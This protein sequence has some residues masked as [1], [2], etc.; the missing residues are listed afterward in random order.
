MHLKS[1]EVQTKRLKIAGLRNSVTEGVPLIALHGWLD[2]AASFDF[3][4]D[5]LSV[6][7]PFFAIDLPGHGQSEHRPA[8]SA[9]HLLENILD[10]LAF[11][12][13]MPDLLAANNHLSVNSPKGKVTELEL[14]QSV[15]PKVN[16]LGHSLGGIIACLVAAAAP[17]RVEKLILLDSLGPLTDEIEAVLPQ[18]RKAVAKASKLKSSLSVFPNLEMAIRARMAGLGRINREA[19]ERLVC[20]GVQAVEGGVIWSSDSRLLKPSFLRLNEK[21]VEAIF[22][23]IECPVLLLTGMQGYFSESEA[24]IKRINYIQRIKHRCVE[25]G[26]HFHMDGDIK[27]TAEFINAFLER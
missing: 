19:S 17:E 13:E 18:L 12:D 5:E 26:H 11:F 2:N 3:L 23:G 7:R 4:A 16:L 6:D 9:Y 10:I 27:A 14:A 22:A 20:R 1:F 24:L 21:Q 25:G 15:T 8:A